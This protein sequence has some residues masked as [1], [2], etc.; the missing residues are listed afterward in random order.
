MDIIPFAYRKTNYFL[1]VGNIDN[2]IA[3][4]VGWPGTYF[5]YAR[6]MKQTGIKIG[7]VK[8]AMVSHFHPDHAGLVSEMI[9][10]DVACIVFENQI[11]TIDEMERMI[12]KKQKN[13]IPIDRKK[14]LIMET[15]DTRDWFSHLGIRG[16][17]ICTAGHSADSVSFISDD[18]QALIGDLVPENIAI[19]PGSKASWQMLRSKKVRKIFPAHGPVHVLLSAK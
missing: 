9:K 16:E 13:Y 2:V 7:Q 5:E 3:F 10:N 17:V 1:I 4:D 18:G 6:V 14:L 11:D 8:Y 12:L 15:K 19:D